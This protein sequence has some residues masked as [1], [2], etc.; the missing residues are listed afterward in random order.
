MLAI[1]ERYRTRRRIKTLLRQAESEY[2]S[3]REERRQAADPTRAARQAQWVSPP[4]MMALLAMD[5]VDTAL[6]TQGVESV[7]LRLAREH[8]AK[9]AQLREEAESLRQTVG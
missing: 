4:L 9:A 7:H 8:E 3:A 1:V 6:Q 5:V 2:S